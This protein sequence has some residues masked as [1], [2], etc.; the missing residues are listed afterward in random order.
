MANKTTYD[1]LVFF[2]GDDIFLEGDAGRWAFLIQSGKI[3]VFKRRPNGSELLLATLGPGRLFGE[4]ALIDDLPRS[5]TAR[6]LTK[7]TLILIDRELVLEKI[8]KSP[9]LVR[10]LLQN[11]SS[12]LRSLN[13][14]HMEAAGTGKDDDPRPYLGSR[15]S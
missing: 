10:E 15:L 13:R 4:M 2:E 12:N 8:A 6:A 11:L 7:A 5:A 9:P 3:G 1:R 14:R